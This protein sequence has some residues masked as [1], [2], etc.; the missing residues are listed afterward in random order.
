[1]RFVAT[2]PQ[3]TLV[4]KFSNAPHAFIA[5]FEND[6]RSKTPTPS[7]LEDA[8]RR[9]IAAA[10]QYHSVEPAPVPQT[11]A[12]NTDTA[13]AK[14]E[15][16]SNGQPTPSQKSAPSSSPPARVAPVVEEEIPSNTNRRVALN[17]NTA[18]LLRDIA[19]HPLTLTT[20]SHN[21]LGIHW[22][23]GDRSK[24][25]LLRLGLVTAERV[26]T[27]AKRGGT[28]SALRLTPAGWAWLGRKP[29]KGTRGG[30][31]VQHEFLILQLS[32]LIQG[33]AI[34]TLGAD[35]VIP[36]NTNEHEQFHRVL[37]TLCTR[38]IALNDGDTIAIEVE[39]SRP[40]ITAPRNVAR[41]RGFT[42][43]V[44]AVL[45]GTA[46]VRTI[47]PTDRVFVVDVLRL[48]DALRLTEG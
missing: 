37:E 44:I 17:T 1:M 22:T 24:Q 20:L 29:P 39:C 40:E 42:F 45:G 15:C 19:E 30:D 14:E 33:S 25:L 3:G 47:V 27:S 18:A 21:R 10:A 28:G 23:Q 11:I 8:R 13:A 12:S 9:T 34:E 7:I 41:D 16:G 35:L 5:T 38:T 6:P 36:Y 26:R 31:S 4:A 32:H 43:T 2:M 46:K 48:L